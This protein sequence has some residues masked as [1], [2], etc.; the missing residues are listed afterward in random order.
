[1]CNPVPVTVTGPKVPKGNVAFGWKEAAG[2]HRQFGCP[3]K[4][5]IEARFYPFLLE[6]VGSLE[7]PRSTVQGS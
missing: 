1:M 7:R 4:G 3:R 6:C 5:P 2:N